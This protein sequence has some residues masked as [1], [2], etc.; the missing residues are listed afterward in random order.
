MN[1]NDH[2]GEIDSS[3]VYEMTAWM[4]FVRKNIHDINEI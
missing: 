3:W 2:M 4:N 1:E